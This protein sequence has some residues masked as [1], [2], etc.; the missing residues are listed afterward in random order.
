MN[1]SSLLIHAQPQR[2]EHVRAQLEQLPGV[3]VHAVTEEGRLIV[4]V[5]K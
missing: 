3:E 2:A 5:E 4:T 1:I